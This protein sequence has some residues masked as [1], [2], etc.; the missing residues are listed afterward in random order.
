MNFDKQQFKESLTKRLKR[1]YGKDFSQATAHDLFDTVSA[2]ALELIMNNW[3]ETRR[4]Y[5]K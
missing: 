5:E 4:Q 1:Q 3:M 2:S